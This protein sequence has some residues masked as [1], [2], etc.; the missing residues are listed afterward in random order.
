MRV[1]DRF[2]D[3]SW[4]GMVTV[5]CVL[6]QPI[7]ATEKHKLSSQTDCVATGE[8]PRKRWVLTT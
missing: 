4:L 2:S 3:Q 6:V 5:V 8:D 1:L 7:F